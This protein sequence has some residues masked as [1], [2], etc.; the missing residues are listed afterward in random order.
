M[1]ELF[2]LWQT[3][4]GIAS[5][6]IS[7]FLGWGLPM[8]IPSTPYNGVLIIIIGIVVSAPFFIWAYKLYRHQKSIQITDKEEHKNL[9]DDIKADLVNMSVIER[10]TATKISS[11]I[12]LPKET[13][14]QIFD[15]CEGVLDD[16]LSRVDSICLNKEYDA[17]IMYCEAMGK[18]LDMNKVGL[19]FALIN[20]EVYKA[21]KLDLEQKRLRLKPAK[22]H[23]FTQSNIVRIE[24]L[25][26]AVNSFIILRG[27]LGK[28][29]GYIKETPIELRLRLEGLE[30]A[31]GVILKVMLDDLEGDWSK[32]KKK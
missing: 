26:Y 10:N 22:R 11:Q 15:D 32:E 29:A 24:K 14:I 31:S 3:W 1:R 23:K 2:K 5:F 9:L 17:L 30:N 27:M 13:V 18:I 20:N 25:S 6:V 21:A 8:I 4:L 19:K 16:C 12:D 28:F 7:Q